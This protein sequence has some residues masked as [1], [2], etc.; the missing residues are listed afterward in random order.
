MTDDADGMGRLH[1]IASS[2]CWFVAFFGLVGRLKRRQNWQHSPFGVPKFG[3]LPS[4]LSFFATA[5]RTA[6]AP[7]PPH[8]TLFAPVRQRGEKGW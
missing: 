8:P 7:P 6:N 2:L 3:E 1:E 4:G 5:W